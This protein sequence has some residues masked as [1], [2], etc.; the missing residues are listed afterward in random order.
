MLSLQKRHF[1]INT[2]INYI[3][4]AMFFN[5][6]LYFIAIFIYLITDIFIYLILTK[7]AFHT[8]E[9]LVRYFTISN[10]ATLSILP[11]PLVALFT[12]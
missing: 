4:I 5:F 6:R 8:F 2:F 11:P 3:F 9:R 7:S 10:L 1:E 12:A